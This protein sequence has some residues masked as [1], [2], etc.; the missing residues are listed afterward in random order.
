MKPI[1]ARINFNIKDRVTNLFD[2]PNSLKIQAIIRFMGCSVYIKIKGT[3][4]YGNT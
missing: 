1:Q 2:K 4:Y 3:D